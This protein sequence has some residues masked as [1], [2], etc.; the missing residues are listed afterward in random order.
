MTTSVNDKLLVYVIADYG[1]LHDLAFA[2]VTQRL[3]LELTGVNSDIHT[4]AVPAFDTFATGFALAQTA[5]NSQLGTRQKFFVNT[6]PRKD[7]LAPRVKNSGEGFVYVK[8]VNGVEICAVNSGH[9]LAFV[10][11]AALEIRKINCD[12]HGSQ[13]RSRD[14]F[15][16]AFATIAKGDYSILGE[17]VRDHV[18]DFPHDVVCYTD[19]Y[20]NLKCSMDPERLANLKDKHL[21]LD[22]NGR[23]QVARAAEGIFGV[24]DGEYCISQGSSGWTYPNGKVMKFTEVVKR[25]GNAAKTFGKPPGGLPIHWRVVE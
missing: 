1:D 8:L 21:I 2:E 25:G 14:I 17:D 22:I 4:F 6:A 16:H 13:F 15:P 10:K 19:G 9:S 7:D 20:G 23:Q 18:P 11:D 24:A 12:A 5:I 3:H